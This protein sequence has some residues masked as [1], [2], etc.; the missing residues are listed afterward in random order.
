MAEKSVTQQ[1]F[2]ALQNGRGSTVPPTYYATDQQRDPSCV[3]S[4]SSIFLQPCDG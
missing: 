2:K 1:A 4:F 3:C